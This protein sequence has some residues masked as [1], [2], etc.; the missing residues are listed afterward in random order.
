MKNRVVVYS[1]E[2]EDGFFLLY[3]SPSYSHQQGEVKNSPWE[4]WALG[5]LANNSIQGMREPLALA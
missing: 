5:T 2:Q 4:K 1:M 3:T